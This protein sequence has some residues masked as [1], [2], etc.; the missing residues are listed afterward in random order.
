VGL[1]RR[2][3][4]ESADRSTGTF[5]AERQHDAGTESLKVREAKAPIRRVLV[6]LRY[7]SGMAPVPEELRPAVSDRTSSS[8][9]DNMESAVLTSFISRTPSGRTLQQVPR[10]SPRAAG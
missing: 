10:R 8:G 6:S 2:P 1:S 5:R 3:K 4:G 9:S 7:R